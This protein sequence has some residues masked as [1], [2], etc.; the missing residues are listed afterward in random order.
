MREKWSETHELDDLFGCLVFYKK[1]SGRKILSNPQFIDGTLIWVFLLETCFILLGMQ[2][3]ATTFP[4]KGL[5]LLIICSSCVVQHPSLPEQFR[6]VVLLYRLH[7]CKGL[8]TRCDATISCNVIPLGV[9]PSCPLL[10]SKWPYFHQ[11]WVARKSDCKCY[12]FGVSVQKCSFISTLRDL[13]FLFSFFKVA[14][15]LLLQR[16]WCSESK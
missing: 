11:S 3:F 1:L 7:Y 4:K 5:W 14:L 6:V 2:C 16:M 15:W 12:P 9:F 13:K 10:S 8:L